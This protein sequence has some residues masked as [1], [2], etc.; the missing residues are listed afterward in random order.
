M[1]RAAVGLRRLERAGIGD[2]AE[3][4]M[5]A[6]VAEFE[7]LGPWSLET[8][9]RFWEGGPTAPGPP[10]TCPR[11]ASSALARSPAAE[12]PAPPDT[13]SE[14]PLERSASVIAVLRGS[15]AGRPA[16]Y[17]A[18]ERSLWLHR[19]IASRAW[20]VHGAGVIRSQ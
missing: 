2:Q 13:L 3:R 20:Q 10:S 1:W 4:A 16:V 17:V 8:S 9:R 19:G 14:P 11:C 6:R 5:A 15:P 18:P 7:V 12:P